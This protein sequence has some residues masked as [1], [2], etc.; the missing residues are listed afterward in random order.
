MG[1]IS[2]PRTHARPL[3]ASPSRGLLAQLAELVIA[4]RQ[5]ARERRQLE[6]LDDHALADLGLS[7]ADVMR[8][9]EKRFWQV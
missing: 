1:T 7:R 2:P 8:E 4:W 6:T 5:R 9:I 3:S